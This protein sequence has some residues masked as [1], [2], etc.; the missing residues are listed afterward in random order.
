MK[1]RDGDDH[2]IATGYSAD[3]LGLDQGL[4]E[5]TTGSPEQPWCVGLDQAGD[6]RLVEVTTG[7]PEATVLIE[8]WP[9]GWPLDLFCCGCCF[10]LQRTCHSV[11]CFRF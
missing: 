8:A 7:S 6:H 1:G 9:G 5:I 10:Y 2:K 3:C 11:M 4:M